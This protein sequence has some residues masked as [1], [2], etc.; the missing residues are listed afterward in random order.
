[1]YDLA[2]DPGE[3]VNVWPQ[4]GEEG[5]RLARAAVSFL[6]ECETPERYLEPRRSALRAFAS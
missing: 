5:R 2:A 4:G 3:E 6:E 1:L